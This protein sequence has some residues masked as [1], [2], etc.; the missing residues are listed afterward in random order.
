MTPLVLAAVAS[1]AVSGSTIPAASLAISTASTTAVSSAVFDPISP[2]GIVQKVTEAIR[3]QT[4]PPLGAEPS[5]AAA[6]KNRHLQQIVLENLDIPEISRLSLGDHW[7]SR[8]PAQREEFVQL[9][10]QVFDKL[11][12]GQTNKKLFGRYHVN[13]GAETIRGDGAK[14]TTSVKAK[15]GEMAVEYKLLRRGD[16]WKIY[17]IIVDDVSTVENFHDQFDQIITEESYPRLLQKLRSKLKE[18]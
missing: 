11:T 17:D 15:E 9:M 3:E 10:R 18:K 16:F 4:L 8:S 6:K 12:W 1:L 2:R 7:Q 13:Y 14:V 5:P